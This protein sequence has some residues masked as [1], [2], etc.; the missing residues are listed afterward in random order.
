MLT[1]ILCIKGVFKFEMF[2]EDSLKMYN[3]V[4]VLDVGSFEVMKA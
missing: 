3:L 4:L 2:L 1:Y